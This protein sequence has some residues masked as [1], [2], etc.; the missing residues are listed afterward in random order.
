MWKYLIRVED[1]QNLHLLT[2][3]FRCSARFLFSRNS[4]LKKSQI[5][6]ENL[7]WQHWVQL[8]TIFA[9]ISRIDISIYIVSF[10]FVLLQ[11]LI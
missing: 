6:R 7:N 1:E 9:L 4:T 3:N 8:I 5:W 2:V 11:H 10:H